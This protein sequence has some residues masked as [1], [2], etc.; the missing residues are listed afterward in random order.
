MRC[1]IYIEGYGARAIRQSY[2]DIVFQNPDASKTRLVLMPTTRL[3]VPL[4]DKYP[5]KGKNTGT[6]DVI[7]KWSLNSVTTVGIRN[8]IAINEDWRIDQQGTHAN[9]PDGRPQRGVTWANL[10]LQYGGRSSDSQR[11]ANA[12]RERKSPQSTS[13][14]EV[15]APLGVI[16]SAKAFQ[17]AFAESKSRERD[18]GVQVWMYREERNG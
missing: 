5:A 3:N 10:Q 15:H 18:G 12:L 7:S 17:R 9:G 6:A 16:F 13:V 8:Q 14:A 1:G 2:P 4:I 11:N